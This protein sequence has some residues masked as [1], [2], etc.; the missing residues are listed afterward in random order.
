M[1]LIQTCATQK[2]VRTTKHEV[3]QYRVEYSNVL[4]CVTQISRRAKKI[5]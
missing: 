2:F 5:R 1:E 4:Q 3:H